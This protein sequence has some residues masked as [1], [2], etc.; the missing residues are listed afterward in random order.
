M[1]LGDGT[2]NAYMSNTQPNSKNYAPRMGL[3]S[4]YD[5]VINRAVKVNRGSQGHLENR[6]VL[7]AVSISSSI[8]TIR[9]NESLPHLVPQKTNVLTGAST[10]YY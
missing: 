5:S 1:F 9:E 4:M 6:D 8:S 10:S 3:H 7:K 2:D